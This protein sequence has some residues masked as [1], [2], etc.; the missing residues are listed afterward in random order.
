ML[1]RLDVCLLMKNIHFFLFSYWNTNDYFIKSVSDISYGMEYMRSWDTF[2]EFFWCSTLF[3]FITHSQQF[4]YFKYDYLN[5]IFGIILYFMQP[6]KMI[7]PDG[8]VSLLSPMEG[9]KRPDSPSAA[10]YSRHGR[11]LKWIGQVKKTL[12]PWSPNPK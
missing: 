5:I 7:I 4:L 3:T 8:C 11:C 9:K 10:L 6:R 12:H 2:Q 1:N